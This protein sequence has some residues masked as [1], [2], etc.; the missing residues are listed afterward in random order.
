MRLRRGFFV[1]SRG[2]GRSR[3]W[4]E[5]GEVTILKLNSELNNVGRFETGWPG[6]PVSSLVVGCVQLRQK[7]FGM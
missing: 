2:E 3:G 5:S 6:V 1:L 4:R 7:S